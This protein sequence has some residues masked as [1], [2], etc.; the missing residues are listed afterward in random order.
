MYSP[1]RVATASATVVSNV[2][3]LLSP[4]E[5]NLG[6]LGQILVGGDPATATGCALLAYPNGMHPRTT[7]AGIRDR[8][9][10]LIKLLGFLV[11]VIVG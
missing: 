6:F 9:D 8:L 4:V 7:G 2:R 3:S 10:H 11:T 1:F 5:P